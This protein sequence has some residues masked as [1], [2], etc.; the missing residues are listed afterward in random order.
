MNKLDSNR[1]SV[2]SSTPPKRIGNTSCSTSS[3]HSS[4][5]NSFN[6]SSDNNIGQDKDSNSNR[7]HSVSRPDVSEA[8]QNQHRRA[9]DDASASPNAAGRASSEQVVSQQSKTLTE[10]TTLK[11][12]APS[13]CADARLSRCSMSLPLDAATVNAQY[14]QSPAT[15]H[16]HRA[17]RRHHHHNHHGHHR[18]HNHHNHHHHHHH[19]HS[20]HSQK[21]NENCQHKRCT[22]TSAD[23]N[24]PMCCTRACNAARAQRKQCACSPN[25]A[26]NRAQ[27]DLLCLVEPARKTAPKNS[28][29]KP[30]E[31]LNHKPPNNTKQEACKSATLC[32]PDNNGKSHGVTVTLSLP[33]TTTPSSASDATLPTI[34]ADSNRAQQQTKTTT[35]P[36][37]A[38]GAR[39]TTSPSPDFARRKSNET[40]NTSTSQRSQSNSPWNDLLTVSKS[41][42]NSSA[43]ATPNH[44]ANNNHIS[45]YNFSYSINN[46]NEPQMIRYLGSSVQMRSEQKATK[47]LGVVF[48]TF[49]IC[50]TPFFVINFTQAFVEREQLSQY[51]SNE[52]MTTFLWLGY[53]SS[54]INPVIYTVFNRNFRRAF[55]QL[56]LCRQPKLHLHNARALRGG[57]EMNKSF[58][59]SHFNNYNN[60]NTSTHNNNITQTN[61]S[62]NPLG[63]LS[64]NS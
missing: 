60:N 4:A 36:K 13:C 39:F 18:H 2:S 20:K 54:T 22:A 35:A 41:S 42:A 32:R 29:E 23:A 10:N 3:L 47:V 45:S 63:G 58:R 5:C 31:V 34:Q 48:F 62:V 37:S 6:K 15:A 1:C 14:A 17:H 25:A 24:R 61:A 12:R 30:N 50:W 16:C 59:I 27:L 38:S 7:P 40:L 44:H 11:K 52:M 19:R 21:C 9:L 64:N 51:I 55:R 57:S 49:V 33:T 26:D 43:Q 46:S 56:L 53:I 8:A 28:I